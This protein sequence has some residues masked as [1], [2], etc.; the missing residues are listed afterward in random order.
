MLA[1]SAAPPVSLWTPVRRHAVFR[2]LWL[3]GVVSNV[4]TWMQ[5]VGAVWLMASI[6]PAPLMVA[7][8]QT[9]TSAP[10]FLLALPAGALAD[11]V[12]RRWLLVWTQ[13]WM[14]AAAA[15]LG[16]LTIAGAATPTLLLLLTFAV[17]IGSALSAPAWQA[18]LPDLVPRDELPQAV[19]LNGV[20]VNIARAIG[21]ALGGVVVATA[22]AG[23][24]F[25]V[26]AAS[27]VGVIA[28]VIAWRERRPHSTV[29]AEHLFA[30]MRSGVLYVRH[31]PSVRA[32]LL[33]TTIFLSAASALWALMPVIAQQRGFGAAGYGV[34]L[35]CLGGGAVAGAT[36]LTPALRA[37]STDRLV[38]LGTLVFAATTVLLAWVGTLAVLCAIMIAAGVAW[39]ALMS[40]F[41][42]D[43][44]LS[45][46]AWVR[47]RGLGIYQLAAQGMLAGGS[48]VWGAIAERVGTPMA[49][50]WSAVGL[51]VGIAAA[52]WWRLAD[53]E[54]ADLT[55]S[56]HWPDPTVAS[57][58][59]PDEGPVLVSVE[60]QIDPVRADEF[61]EVMSALAR[62]RRRDGAMQWHLFSDPAVPGR[63]VEQ[64]MS[65][66]WADHLRQ[67]ERVTVHDRPI[68]DRA[69]AFHLGPRPQ[70]V[71][72][73]VA[74]PLRRR[75]R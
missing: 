23:V 29:P 57:A 19:A 27:F 63:Y 49:L 21:P 13:V 1:E 70:Q 67:H 62:V 47:A 41:M 65:R 73:L 50:V 22:G 12:D 46:P 15:A 11:V 44:Q 31:S 5:N 6:V 53:A 39:I 4:G 36:L 16:L 35:G 32:I 40:V 52:Q 3:A 71:S 17:G 74:A 60:Y 24:V 26:N 66:S 48:A 14:L 2:R 54:G 25:L 51:V 55:P 38:V 9:A 30:A 56:M 59:S 18:I 43:A 68:E 10:F 72:H 8:V 64:F 7:L 20:G 34:L 33:R 45:V 42:V 58:P 28:A 61:E 69:R 75:R 37:F